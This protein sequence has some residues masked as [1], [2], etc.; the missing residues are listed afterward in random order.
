VP[1]YLTFA[2]H[3]PVAAFGGLAVGEARGGWDRPGRSAVL[4]L[5]AAAL[6]VE[7]TDDDAH[8][9]LAAR[10]GLAMLVEAAGR[11]FTDYHTAQVPPRRAGRR[12]HTRAEELAEPDLNTVQSWRTYRSGVLALVAAW[13]RAGAPADAIDAMAAALARPRFAPYLGRRSCPLGLPMAPTALE[14]DDPVEALRLRRADGPEAAVR[15]GSGG[16][17]DALGLPRR[18]DPPL[19]CMDADEA[20]DRPTRR[21]ETRRDEPASRRRWQFHL[22]EEAVFPLPPPPGGA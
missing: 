1:R 20:G 15:G 9:A 21:I 18:D 19:V 2:L 11:P 16:A 10:W 12:R 6:G 13:P 22:R 8:G 14:A 4:G 7:R 5:M 3:A 17:R